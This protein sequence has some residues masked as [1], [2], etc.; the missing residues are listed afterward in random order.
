MKLTELDFGNSLKSTIYG[1][2]FIND[3]KGHFEDYSEVDARY[4]PQCPAPYIDLPYTLLPSERV[5]VLQ[6]EPSLELSGWTCV[7][8][9][10]R[11]LWHPDVTRRGL[12][13]DGTVRSQPTSSTRTLLTENHPRVYIKTD[14]N[15]KH[16]RFIRRLHRSSVEHSM[17]IC[18]DLRDTCMNLPESSRYAFLPESL[19]LVVRGG[20]HEGSGVV[21]R[22]TLPCPFAKDARVMMPYHSLYAN[23][24]R[25]PDDKP[26]LVQAVELHAGGNALDYFVS[27]IVGPIIETWVFLVSTRGILPELH[28]QNA[29]AEIDRNL[30]VRRVA[31][32]DFQGTYSDARIRSN[33][34][35]PLFTK[36]VAGSELGT[37]AGSQYS[38]VFD[39]MIGRYLLS[40]LTKKPSK[41]SLSG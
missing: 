29:L 15:K 22:E 36:H 17:A 21:F 33:L 41:K 25:H 6:S 18:N 20:D 1:E 19:G 5:I 4:D 27:E 10:Y 34:G 7:D 35:L 3:T 11:F 31:H 40:R 37:T 39:G 13:I 12:Q 23:D 26:L 9:K 24:P 2:R 14:L 30:R 28:G 8:G 16:F 38:L 32:R